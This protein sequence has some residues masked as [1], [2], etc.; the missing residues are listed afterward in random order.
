[1]QDATGTVAWEMQTAVTTFQRNHIETGS[2]QQIELHAQLHFGQDSYF[3]VYNSQAFNEAHNAV[4]FELLLDEQVLDT[5]T[6]ESGHVRRHL[7]PGSSVGASRADQVVAKQ[8]GWSCQ[9]DCI[10]YSQPN[11]IHADLTRQEF[12]QRLDTRQSAATDKPL[13][14]A[15]GGASFLIPAAAT[16]FATALFTGPPLLQ[17]TSSS[18][19]LFTNLF[20]PGSSLASSLRAVLW[21]T[22]PAPEVSVLLLDWASLLMNRGVTGISKVSLWIV[23]SLVTGRFDKVRQLVFGQVVL[24][25]NQSAA[26]QGKVPSQDWSL[27]VTERNNHALQVL[28]E[29]LADDQNS[30]DCFRLALLYGC[31]HCP[32]LH[33]RLVHRGFVPVCTEYRTA[34]SVPFAFSNGVGSRMGTTDTKGGQEVTTM[35]IASILVALPIYFT[36]GGLDWIGTLQN[37]VGDAETNSVTAAVDTLL[38]LF[39]HVLL[40][41]GLSKFFLDWD[42]G[43]RKNESD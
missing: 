26:A 13:W 29:T 28:D 5:E 23:Q 34:W 4:L 31:S 17:E 21:M 7:V 1:V 3:N 35:Q 27:L 9:V 6:M 22:V 12:L 39:R 30:S 36:L 19:R 33:S 20:L 37:I 38:Y 16:E 25:A 32:D 8:Y 41:V 40:Y 42:G 15:A 14:Q 11:W 43:L 18:R 10:D 24:V 2:L